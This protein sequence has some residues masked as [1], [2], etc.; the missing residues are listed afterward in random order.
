MVDEVVEEE[1]EDE[2]ADGGGA[3]DNDGF[4]L[5]DTTGHLSTDIESS[6]PSLPSLCS[7][8]S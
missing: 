3:F 1:E 6:L 4:N 2:V 5:L 8:L 7:S